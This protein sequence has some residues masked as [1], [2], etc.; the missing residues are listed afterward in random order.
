MGYKEETVTTIIPENAVLP[1]SPKPI[2]RDIYIKAVDIPNT[3][4]DFAP[5]R[6]LV[7]LLLFVFIISV[8]LGMGIYHFIFKKTCSDL[9]K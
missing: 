8:L 7:Y 1:S 6:G 3:A 4:D 9:K 5:I 2:E